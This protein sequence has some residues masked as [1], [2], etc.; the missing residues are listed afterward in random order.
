MLACKIFIYAFGFQLGNLKIYKMC[1][2]V[3]IQLYFKWF[4]FLFILYSQVQNTLDNP[5]CT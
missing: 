2:V 5:Y 3:Q 1:N 4:C